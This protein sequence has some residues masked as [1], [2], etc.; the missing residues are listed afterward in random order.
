MRK[1]QS[2][3]IT[4][5]LVVLLLAPAILRAEVARVEI[6]AR[7]DAANGAPF[8]SVGVY[9]QL[10]GK[11]FFVVDPANPRNRVIVDLDKAPKNS[12]GLVEMSADFAVLRPKDPS[13]G[14]GVAL[15]DVANRGNKTVL[16]GFNR[17]STANENGDGLLMRMGYTVVWVGWE[18]DVPQR[19]GAIR[20]EVPS[21]A[22]VT[23][24]VRSNV[25]PAARN[26][27]AQFGDLASYPPN[28]PASPENTLTVRDGARGKPTPIERNQWTLNGNTV[29]LQGGF[30]P[31]RTYELSYEASNPPVAGLG[32][33]A[34]RDA[35]SWMKYAPDALVSAKQ[36]L[37]FG[38]SQ[39][40]RFLR[41]FLYLG[42]NADEKNRMVFDAVMAHIAGASRI[43]VNNR[44]ATPTTQGQFNATSFPFADVS[45]R[46]PATGVEEGALDNAR[47]R[48]FA[49]KI[50]YTNTGVEYW[51]GGRSAALIHTTPD[52]KKDLALPDNE[53][54][55]LLSGSQHGPGRFPPADARNGQQQENPTEYWY[56]MR[57]LLVAMDKWMREG[58]APP[59]SQ[60]PRLQNKTLVK[61]SEVSFPEIP[62]VTSPKD[63]PPAARGVNPMIAKEGAPGTLLP[64]FVPQ[65]DKDGIEIAGIRLPYISVPLAT[66]TGWNFRNAA[67]GGSNQLYP[68]IGSFI[69]FPATAE[70]REELSDPRVSIAERYPSRQAYL[71]K[72]QKAGARL[73]AD[74][75]LLSEDLPNVVKRAGDQWDLLVKF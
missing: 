56:V 19:N 75:F 68:L 67:V 29:T 33:A 63:L 72:I 48:G 40:G 43:D 5:A 58:V 28:N 25:I 42:F 54:V 73:V 17:A 32:L 20:I 51:G 30:E 53:R 14:N 13:K 49:P 61:A 10:V 24:M 31:G 39:S 62:G 15:F 21:A 9:E 12:A 71:E 4:I 70:K 7:F 41:N 37:A 60:Y 18:F 2:V 74:R 16:S 22:G 27:T 66:T 8:G 69:P 23:G 65:T 36:T 11:I 26:A 57:A 50:F 35:A 34:I 64:F 47:A 46:D 6:G 44:W 38:S 3:R 55:Y 59:A 1:E 45:L 52:G